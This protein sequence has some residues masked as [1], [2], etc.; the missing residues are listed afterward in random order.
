MNKIL[1]LGNGFNADLGLKV[2]YKDFFDSCQYHN[3]YDERSCVLQSGF[4]NYVNENKIRHNYNIEAILNA[5][6]HE[7]C[8]TDN[9][10]SD[11][12][13]LCYLEKAFSAFVDESSKHFDINSCAFSVL[14]EFVS[15][16]EKKTEGEYWVYS[17]CYTAFDRIREE[18]SKSDSLGNDIQK[19]KKGQIV[20][21]PLGGSS[22]F[23]DYIHGISREDCCSV[24]FG[25]SEEQIQDCDKE[26]IRSYSFVLK[27]NH[28]NYMQCKKKYLLD[29]LNKSENVTFFGFSFSDSDIPYVRQW[30]NTKITFPKKRKVTLYLYD[31]EDFDNALKK[32]Q[33]IAGDNWTAFLEHYNIVKQLTQK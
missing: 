17:F 33:M 12:Q 19:V 1:I 32:M 25:L 16:R 15:E 26:I 13:D 29:S 30:L 20:G 2:G 8:N 7:L 14:R 11:K 21:N 3:Y 18:L 5:Y 31:Q 28:L 9:A 27:E 10:K 4:A 22:I 24:I 23:I 6:V